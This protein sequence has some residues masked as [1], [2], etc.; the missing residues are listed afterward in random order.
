MKNGS[1]SMTYEWDKT[2]SSSF[3]D[4][5][6]K[7]NRLRIKLSDKGMASIKITNQAPDFTISE[8]GLYKDSSLGDMRLTEKLRKNGGN[9][10]ISYRIRN[11]KNEDTRAKMVIAHYDTNGKLVGIISEKSFGLPSDSTTRIIS[12]ALPIAGKTG[13]IRAF[14]WSDDGNL[15]PLTPKNKWIIN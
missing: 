4:E 15:Y 12:D 14:V 11:N 13:E 6:E 2:L 5:V 8:M 1:G 10:Y 7:T 9:Q 3:T